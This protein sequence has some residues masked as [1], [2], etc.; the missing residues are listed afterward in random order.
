[1]GT[2][3]IYCNWSWYFS[4]WMGLLMLLMIGIMLVAFP[5][6]SVIVNGARQEYE[7][8]IKNELYLDLT[9]NIVGITDWIL[10]NVVVIMLSYMNKMRKN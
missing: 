5:I 2:L 1:M 10:L 9:D 4:I 6:W 3:C 7:K 8:K